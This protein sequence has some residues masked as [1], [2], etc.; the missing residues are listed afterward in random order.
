MKKLLTV[1]FIL[2]SCS[3]F[4][5]RYSIGLSGGYGLGV[6]RD[7]IGVNSSQEYR[8]GQEIIYS[9][10]DTIKASLGKGLKINFNFDYQLNKYF[11]IGCD[12]VYHRGVT[13]A[14]D[15]NVDSHST[16]GTNYSDYVYS[17]SSDFKKISQLQLIPN[18]KFQFG[19]VI[20]PYVKMG[21]VVGCFGRLTVEFNSSEKH[22]Y[23]YS[24]YNP[25]IPSLYYVDTSYTYSIH[26][27]VIYKDGI[28]YGY[29]GAIGI[30]VASSKM[31]SFVFEISYVG[32]S[33]TPKESKVVE[34]TMNGEDKLD[35]SLKVKNPARAYSSINTMIGI[36]YVFGKP[37]NQP[38]PATQ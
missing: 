38:N 5:Q 9:P 24:V 4:G 25:F 13:Y 30:D 1:I 36:R 33:W 15:T 26:E 3:S 29:T 23:N 27:K 18:V 7:L 6:Q 37:T 17:G 10:K 8:N 32:M 35:S 2:I 14:I 21:F 31:L 12:V 20:K 16:N 19:K 11:R 34:Y 28:S 22:S